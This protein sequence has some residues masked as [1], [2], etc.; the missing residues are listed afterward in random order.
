[1]NILASK[2]PFAPNLDFTAALWLTSGRHPTLSRLKFAM[3]FLKPFANF[4]RLSQ[5]LRVLLLPLWQLLLLSV[6]FIPSKTSLLRKN[7]RIWL[8]L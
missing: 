5:R 1:M 6:P 4:C 8:D 2:L 3:I 7:L